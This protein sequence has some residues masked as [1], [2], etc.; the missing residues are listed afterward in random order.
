[1]SQLKI[2]HFLVTGIERNV[3]RCTF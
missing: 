3:F 2:W 1:L